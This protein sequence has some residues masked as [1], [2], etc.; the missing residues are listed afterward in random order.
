MIAALVRRR[1][2]PLLTLAMFMP[3][4][5]TSWLNLDIDAAGRYAIGYMAAHALLAA[6][7]F[8]LF[9]RKVQIA[10]CSPS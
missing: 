1:M 2:A 4:A 5:L 8:L 6:D 3:L 7:G 9:G 10:L